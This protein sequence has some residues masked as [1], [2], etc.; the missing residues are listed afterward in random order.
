MI[1]EEI[2]FVRSLDA[3][4]QGGNVGLCKILFQML[5]TADF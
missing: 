5:S 3:S 4:E 2:H 1:G